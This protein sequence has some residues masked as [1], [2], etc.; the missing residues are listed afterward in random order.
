[1]RATLPTIRRATAHDLA[2]ITDIYDEA[3]LNIV[4]TFDTE[5]KTI[6]EQKK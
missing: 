3:I 1:M 5:T 2:A 4:A 6:K